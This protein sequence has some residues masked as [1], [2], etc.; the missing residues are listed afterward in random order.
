MTTLYGEDYKQTEVKELNPSANMGH[1]IWQ[2]ISFR[3]DWLA[4]LAVQGTLK[5][6]IQHHSSKASRGQKLHL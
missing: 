4:L 6:L 2:S 5:S 3:M 1:Q